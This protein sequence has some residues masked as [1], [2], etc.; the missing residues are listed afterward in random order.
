LSSQFGLWLSGTTSD[1]LLEARRERLGLAEPYRVS[2]KH[3]KKMNFQDELRA[4]LCKHN[5]K[6]DER[7]VWD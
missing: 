6:W 5:L 3:H 2:A 4:L 7:Y 1:R